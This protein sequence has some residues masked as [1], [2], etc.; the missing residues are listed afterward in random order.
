M[1][2]TRAAD[3]AVRIMIH[4]ATLPPDSRPSGA[5][6]AKAQDIPEHFAVKVLQSLARA[7]MVAS[8]RGSGGGF[9]LSA[10]PRRVTM[11]DVVEAIEGPIA[12]NACMTSPPSC[13]RM[14]NC[15]AHQVWVVAQQAMVAVLR[16][17][18]IASLAARTQEDS[19]WTSRG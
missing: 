5:E 18:T 19:E 3:Y 12:L 14:Q 6:L 15:A 16:T 8:Q 4:L 2:L 10:D 17:A 9:V 1:Q 7:R 11:L 13:N